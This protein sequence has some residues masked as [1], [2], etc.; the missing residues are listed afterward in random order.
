MAAETVK[1]YL[2][3]Q[4][5]DPILGVLVRVFDATGTT[6]I[7]QDTTVDVGG[8][9]VAEVTLDGDDPPNQYTVRLSKTGVAFDGSLGDDSKSPQ[10]IEIYSPPANAP[11]G[12]NDFD[13]RGE[14]FTRPVSSDARLCRAS[15]F[16]KNAAGQPLPNLDIKFINQ[17][18]PT[19]VDGNAVM[20]ER[21][22]VRTDADGY[23]EFDLYRNG[24]YLAWVQSIQAAD[25]DPASAIS[26]SREV[27]VPDTTSVNLIDLLFPIVAEITFSEDPV[28][29]AV[30]EEKEIT[31]V[32]K[33]TDGRTLTG[34]A[35]EDVLY[36]IADSA[37]ASLRIEA[38]K[39][40]IRGEAAGS[41]EVTATRQDQTI[42]V[43]PSATITGSPL[44]VTVS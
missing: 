42:V 10:L 43:I 22:E 14:T 18:K 35:C 27:V 34:T 44:A 25:D 39:L 24:E 19:I 38:D 8:D 9:A 11:T 26:F 15:G 1:F 30:D 16:F 4:D 6:F 21:V 32:V 41:T 31:A 17:F 36:E 7:T 29:L 2:T 40:T 5:T 23:V 20:G 13:I 37:V 12:K 33:A 3:D 28:T